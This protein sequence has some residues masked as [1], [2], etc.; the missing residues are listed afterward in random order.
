MEAASSLYKV[1]FQYMQQLTVSFN[2]FD[3]FLCVNLSETLSFGVVK[4]TINN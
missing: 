1:C 2:G 4:N 3:C